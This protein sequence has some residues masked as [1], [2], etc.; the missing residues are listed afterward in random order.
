MTTARH[1]SAAR[2]CRRRRS[3]ARKNRCAR[4]S[5]R[6]RLV[7]PF[8]FNGLPSPQRNPYV[9]GIIGGL[10]QPGSAYGVRYSQPMEYS[11]S[12][13]KAGT[14]SVMKFRAPAVDLD[15]RLPVQPACRCP[16]EHLSL[17]SVRIHLPHPC[18]GGPQDEVAQ[19]EDS[20]DFFRKCHPA[21]TR[22]E[23]FER[24]RVGVGEKIRLRHQLLFYEQHLGPSEGP[25]SATM[26]GMYRRWRLEIV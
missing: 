20:S 10:R 8:Q 12:R 5:G 19:F 14:A 13:L 24:T 2:V 15:H 3:S 16:Q 9:P 1:S 17:V 4:N 21:V 7:S 26:Y 22:K 18:L 25:N 23:D 11:S 6:S